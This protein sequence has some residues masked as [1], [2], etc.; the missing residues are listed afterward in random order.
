MAERKNL[1]LPNNFCTLS[2]EEKGKIIDRASGKS[3]SG[4]TGPVHAFS[5]RDSVDF[6]SQV[7]ARQN[8]QA[9]GA[10][11]ERARLEDFHNP[12][13][14]TVTMKKHLIDGGKVQYFSPDWKW[15]PAKKRYENPRQQYYT[16]IE[17]NDAGKIYGQ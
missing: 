5:K 11:S 13:G 15:N 8:A 3:G 6:V 2:P 1:I 4:G 7:D 16:D 10:R 12:P 14:D 17:N 9:E